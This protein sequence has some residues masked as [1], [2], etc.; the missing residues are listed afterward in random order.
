MNQVKVMD[1]ISNVMHKSASCYEPVFGT[2]FK[3]YEF[4]LTLEL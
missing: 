4:H 3:E 2:G 1:I